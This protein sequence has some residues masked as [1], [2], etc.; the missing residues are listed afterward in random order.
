MG[1]PAAGPGLV[2]AV[3]G[4][5]LA[6]PPVRPYHIP[7]MPQ[8]SEFMPAL[9]ERIDRFAHRRPDI[10]LMAPFLV[11]LALLSLK[12]VWPEQNWAAA[13][14]RGVGAVAVVWLFRRHLPLWGRADVWVA[15]PAAVVTAFGWFYGQ[16]LF[17]WWG[18][19]QRLPIPP[20]S[21]QPELYDPTQR[22]GS[23]GLF[24]LTAVTHIA[25]ATT[26]V[27]V[28]EEL[29]WRAFLLRA[30]VNWDDFEKVPLGTFAWRSFLGTSLLSV[31]Q[32]PDN[33]AVSILCWMAWNGL[34]Y[35]RKSILC[36]VLTHGLTNLVLYI[37][38]LIAALHL[39]D[40]R[41]WMHLSLVA[42]P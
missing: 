42:G 39:G 11:Y 18:L 8:G 24:W 28:V 22:L 13:L 5:A 41:A 9:R 10:V 25:V 33:W 6:N 1:W 17:N 19:P 20:F 12:D 4:A 32:H 37:W 29:F 38:V 30:L 26:T 31:L 35:W 7:I 23:G 3:R 15:V 27:A 14:I 21:G 16:Y 34:M 2:L 40:S 36:L